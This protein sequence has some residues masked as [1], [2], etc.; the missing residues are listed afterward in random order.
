MCLDHDKR[1]GRESGT[2]LIELMA[3]LLAIGI[4]G[5]VALPSFL[6]E[7]SRAS[8]TA[9]QENLRNAWTT[10]Q[11]VFLDGSTSATMPTTAD[12]FASYMAVEEPSL[13]W[14]V[15][16]ADATGQIS[17]AV[18]GPTTQLTSFVL[19]S[20]DQ[21]SA[22]SCSTPYGG[23]YMATTGNG[24]VAVELSSDCQSGPYHLE[25]YS[26]PNDQVGMSTPPPPGCPS[27]VAP[28][29]SYCSWPQ[30]GDFP[31]TLFATTRFNGSTAT[32]PLPNGCWQIDVVNGYS[33]AP[34]TLSSVTS[35]LG[36][37]ILW[38]ESGGSCGS[39]TDAG[40]LTPA[41]VS[42]SGP[43][44]P[45]QAVVLSAW[46][47]TAHGTCWSMA[48]VGTQGALGLQP[49]TWYAKTPVGAHGCDSATIGSG[50]S[51]DRTWPS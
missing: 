30:P 26:A 32:A 36:G 50:T 15:G 16:S 47:P 31:Q 40:T 11:T 48:T 51:W 3:V 45:L 42:S 10:A 46:A 24:M 5:A 4:L 17:V 43:Q 27:N 9:A 6:G 25:V 2:T 19:T 34:E 29:N 28:A 22:V 18:I 49:G 1:G 23:N 44:G 41:A 14:T 35:G 38:G 33:G 37:N 12:S 7:R 20:T 21:L 39:A 13:H 8:D